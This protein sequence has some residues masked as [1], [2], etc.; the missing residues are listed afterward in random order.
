MVGAGDDDTCCRRRD[1]CWCAHGCKRGDSSPLDAIR[2]SV[3]AT[4]GLAE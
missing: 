1:R 4:A 2:H 3:T